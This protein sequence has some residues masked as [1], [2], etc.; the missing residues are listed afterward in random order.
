MG[1]ALEEPF[2][3]F[4]LRS[5]WSQVRPSHTSLFPDSSRVTPRAENSTQILESAMSPGDR[6]CDAQNSELA[7]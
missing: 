6:K 5:N 4:A 3:L 7:A 2:A 1:R